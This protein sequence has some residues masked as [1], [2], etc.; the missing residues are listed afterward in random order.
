MKALMRIEL[1]KMSLKGQIRGMVV[2]NMI[3]FF[4]LTTI[5]V[6]E[7]VPEI[8]AFEIVDVI[9]KAVFLIWQSVLISKLI[10]SEFKERTIQQLCTYP[11]NRSNV[12]SAKVGL[13]FVIMLG[14]IWVTQLIQHSLFSGLSLILPEFNYAL[15]LQIIGIIALTS[16]FTVMVG[17]LPI[18]VGLW[19]KSTIAPVITSFLIISVLG[20]SFGDASLDLLNNLI[21]MLMMG[22]VGMA[23]AGFVIRD[24]LKKDLIV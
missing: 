16:L 9:I 2:A 18:A 10:V 8:E 5:F 20:G 24:V 15:N 12:M 3:I 6:T 17:M 7:G 14:F 1:K 11:L 4:L 22:A 19:M 13:I 21:G 23:F